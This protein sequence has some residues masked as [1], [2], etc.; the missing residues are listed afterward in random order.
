MKR[1]TFKLESVLQLRERA[2]AEAQQHHA[3][4]GRRLEALVAE[5]NEAEAEFKALAEQLENLQRSSFRP[6]EHDLLWSALNQQRDHCGRLT[7]KVEIARND[8]EA[9]RE[10]LLA[11][12]RDHEGIL[13]MREHEEQEHARLAEQEERGMIDDIVNA[14]HAAMRGQGGSGANL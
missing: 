2:E 13:K 6:A 11:A 4:A 12:R 7:Q 5:L 3:A 1:F 8:L 14:R 10:M 9:K